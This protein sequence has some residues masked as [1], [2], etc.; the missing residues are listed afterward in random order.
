M[1]TLKRSRLVNKA[2]F[3]KR[4]RLHPETAKIHKGDFILLHDIKLDNQHTYKLTNR[5]GGPYLVHKTLDGG[6]YVLTE[7][8]GSR[9]D[10][11]YAGNRLK[12]YWAR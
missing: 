11:A 2:W 12:Q 7:L 10:G 4:K 8:D 9:L 3:D 1:A 6:A 5:W